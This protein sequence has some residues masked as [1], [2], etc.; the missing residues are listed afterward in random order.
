MHIKW[1]FHLAEVIRS[2]MNILE[3]SFYGGVPHPSL[4]DI[5]FCA[6]IER[7][8]G[9]TVAKSVDTA[10]FG[11]LCFGLGLIVDTLGCT[12]GRGVFYPGQKTTIL[13]GVEP[14][15]THAGGQGS[16]ATILYIG[17]YGLYLVQP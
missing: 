8:S 16:S 4:D 7:M 12:Y 3:G 17:L 2:K 11:D 15:N 13:W 1:A 14:A 5:K 9:K 10:S 6:G